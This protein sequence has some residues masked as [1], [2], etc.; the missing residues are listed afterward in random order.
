MDRKDLDKEYS[1]KI[2]RY[3]ERYPLRDGDY[4]RSSFDPEL[5]LHLNIALRQGFEGNTEAREWFK[6][7]VHYQHPEEELL[8]MKRYDESARSLLKL[9]SLKGYVDNDDV[10]YA[11]LHVLDQEA[12]LTIVPSEFDNA[13]GLEELIHSSTHVGFVV[14]EKRGVYWLDQSKK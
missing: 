13:D 6:E 3:H 12:I 4:Y 14:D 9:D 11:D 1:A 2:G 10:V 7:F 8:I 5:Q